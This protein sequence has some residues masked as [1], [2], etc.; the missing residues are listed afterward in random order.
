ML[1]FM[2]GRHVEL[3]LFFVILGRKGKAVS[4]VD[5]QDIWQRFKPCA[6]MTS[7]I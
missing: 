2:R 3:H 5:L 6:E 1:S 7:G 4:Q